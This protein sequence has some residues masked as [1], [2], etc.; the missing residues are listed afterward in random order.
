MN[1]KV[2]F[3]NKEMT[4]AGRMLKEGQ[5]APDFRV[6]KHD[7]SEV[8]LSDFRGKT[9]ILTTFP[10]LDTPVCEMQ[11]KHFNEMALDLGNDVVILA[12]SRDLPF[13]QQ[14]F[15]S[16]HSIDR[17]TVA[18]DYKSGSLGHNYGLLVRELNLLA[19]SIIIMD[20]DNTIR[21]IQKVREITDSPDYEKALSALRNITENK[22]ST[23]TLGADPMCRIEEE[24][25]LHKI[26]GRPLLDKVPGWSMHG[27]GTLERSWS[28]NNSTQAR[29]FIDGIVHISK[30]FGSL[31]SVH[32]DN[33]NVDVTLTP[34]CK[35]GIT[36]N[37]IN[38]A[39]SLNQ[40]L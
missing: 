1:R 3:K 29:E 9:K 32:W 33:N 7:M 26:E 38:L 36:E 25:P 17:I 10:S 34:A 39:Y 4:L 27:S 40:L 20:K 12:V 8:T 6:L 35:E 24:N 31:P 23:P 22:G 2:T 16:T 13:A 21:Y 11:V 19:R 28:F 30:E 14:R 5:Q 15:C 18:S 37:D